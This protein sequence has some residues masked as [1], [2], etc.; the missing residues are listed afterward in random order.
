MGHP[1]SFALKQFLLL[2]KRTWVVE[3]DVRDDSRHVFHVNEL[4]RA[5]R[6]QSGLYKERISKQ[7][8]GFYWDVWQRVWPLVA[9]AD[10]AER[11]GLGEWWEQWQG[12]PLALSPAQ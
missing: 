3:R 2:L 7:P 9:A 11:Q 5:E 10:G 6:L 4:G 12:W 1:P 8:V